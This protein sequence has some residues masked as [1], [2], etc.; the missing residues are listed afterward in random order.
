MLKPLGDRIL[1]RPEEPDKH[2]GVIE[3]IE[4]SKE[5]TRMGTVLAI[6]NGPE[7]QLKMARAVVERM[8]A[9]LHS[10]GLAFTMS[11]DYEDG[12]A[13]IRNSLQPTSELKPGDLVIFGESAVPITLDDTEY[14]MV[15][16]QDILATYVED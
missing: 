14:L 6:G 15:R 10:T 4:D 3:L 8:H 5:P 1:V 2:E 13:E 7:Q 12:L 9:W 11:S 16:E